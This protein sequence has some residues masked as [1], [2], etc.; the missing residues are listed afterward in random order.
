MH[1]HLLGFLLMLKLSPL[2]KNWDLRILS[3]KTNKFSLS[4]PLVNGVTISFSSKK[5]QKMGVFSETCAFPSVGLYAT[6]VLFFS[7]SFFGTYFLGHTENSTWW[8]EKKI[9]LHVHTHE[10]S[11]RNVPSVCHIVLGCT[12]AGS[13]IFS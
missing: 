4:S 10:Q 6:S 8:F 2:G 1:H 12:C 11:V 3:N 9:R 5:P 13:V 7:Y